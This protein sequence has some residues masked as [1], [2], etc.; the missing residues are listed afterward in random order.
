MNYTLNFNVIALN[1]MLFLKGAG[2]TFLVS[3]IAIIF[4]FIIGLVC[5]SIKSHEIKVASGFVNCYVEVI[6]NTPFLIQLSVIYFA[7]PAFGIMIKPLLAGIIALTINVGAYATEIIRA[8]IESISKDQINSGL[9]LGM[10][11]L[12]ALR[13]IIIYP[14][15]QKMFPALSTIFISLMLGSS[16]LSAIA[17][18]ELTSVAYR[19]T[20]FHF[21]HFEVFLFIAGTYLFLSVILSIIFK[22]IEFKFLSAEKEKIGFRDLIKSVF[23]YSLI[24][25]EN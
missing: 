15:M 8:G 25:R 18:P 19:V 14:A 1:K 2:I 13:Y 21:R 16:I 20:S 4:G 17:T 10:N 24:A 12:Q 11:R 9:A 23:K 5:A 7:F 22:V 3:I 6:R